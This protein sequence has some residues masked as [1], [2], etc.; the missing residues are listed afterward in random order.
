MFRVLL[1]T[2]ALSVL[3]MQAAFASISRPIPTGTAESSATDLF[4]LSADY[5]S[6]TGAQPFAAT[7]FVL[8]AYIPAQVKFY[9]PSGNNSIFPGAFS[10]TVSGDYINNGVTTAFSNQTLIFRDNPAE[11]NFLATGFLTPNDRFSID[12]F[13][14]GTLF[15]SV[16]AGN[17]YQLATLQSG[18]FTIDPSQNSFGDYNGDPAISG[19]GI[20]VTPVPEPASAALLATGLLGLIFAARKRRVQ[21]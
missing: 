11:A 5:D 8:D 12:A 1:V 18:S 13:I 16:S 7:P 15:S 9:N 4:R 2:T 10:L 6:Q 14:Q 17:G 3:P 20:T 21:I 19:G